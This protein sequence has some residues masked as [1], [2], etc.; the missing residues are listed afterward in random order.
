MVIAAV[1]RLQHRGRVQ[2]KQGR[3]YGATLILV[4]SEAHPPAH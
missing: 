3:Y 1:Y 4:V 2:V